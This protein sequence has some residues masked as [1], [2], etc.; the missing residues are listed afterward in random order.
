MR[1]HI[2]LFLILLMSLPA[3]AGNNSKLSPELEGQSAGVNVDV[4]VQYRTQPTDQHEAR[5][6]SHGGA[7]KAHLHGVNGF[8]VSLPATSLAALSSDPDVKY[9]SPDRPVTP[10]LDST[11]AAVNA[12]VAWSSGYDGTGIG[13]AVID[14]GISNAEDLKNSSGALRVVYQ[15]DLVGGGTDDHYGHGNHVAGIAAGNG[16]RST[17]SIYTRTFRGIAPNAKLLNFRVLD[18]N[19]RGTDSSVISAIQQAIALK[20]KYNIRVINLSLGRPVYESYTVDPLCQA[21]ESAWRAGIVVVVAAGNEGRNNSAGTDGYATITAPGN[22]PYVIT[23]GAMKTMGTLTRADDLI[24]SYSS[25]GP[26]LLDHIAKPD[27]VAPGNRTVSLL[28]STATLPSYYPGNAVPIKAYQNTGSG[29]L[30]N[31]YYVLSGSSMATPVVSGAVALLLQQNPKLTPDQVKARLMKTA[32]KVFP[33]YSSVTDRTSGATYTDQYDVF[34][35]GAGYLDIQAALN[36]TETTI[37]AANSPAVTY[38]S[39]CQCVH[40]VKDS[41]ALWGTS[42]IWAASAVWGANVFVGSQSAM[43]GSSALWG[44]SAIWGSNVSPT[45]SSAIWGSGALWGS[46]AI[47]GSNT[48]PAGEATSIV[49]NGEN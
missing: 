46:S 3:W 48:T 21:V 15:A 19:G 11:A 18:Q 27:L 20:S 29:S 1:R 26:T 44:N 9:I 2:S 22:D 40:F 45:S 33:R 31:D 13:I 16:K 25:K 8:A 49:I 10:M 41:S 23:V 24:A 4:I 30:S 39:A 14:S 42:A 47:W 6:Q 12:A 5:I 28:A 38:D 34:T 37:A 35:I 7:L 43:W 32:Y 36:S 17:G